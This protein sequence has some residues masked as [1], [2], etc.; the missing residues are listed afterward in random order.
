MKIRHTAWLLQA[1]L[2]GSLAPALGACRDKAPKRRSP[3]PSSGSKTSAPRGDSPLGP[4]LRRV[5]ADAHWAVVSADLHR[6]QRVLSHAAALLAHHKQLA[7]VLHKWRTRTQRIWGSWPLEAESWKRLNL[8][9]QSG[10]ALYRRAD[11]V[12]V[13]L[14]R[15]R[16][17]AQ[18]LH[19]IHQTIRN[20]GVRK[21]DAVK[22]LRLAG[23]PAFRLDG[24][25]CATRGQL[26]A[27]ANVAPNRFEAVIRAPRRSLW[28]AP[29]AEVPGRYLQA[30]LGF[31]LRPAPGAAPHQDPG[32]V[33]VLQRGVTSLLSTPVQGFWLALSLHRRL[34]LHA[35]AV[36]TPRA[37]P[38]ASL[39]KP[40]HSGL[41]AASGAPL[42]IRLRMGPRRLGD[43]V[44]RLWPALGPVVDLFRGRAGGGENLAE[45]ML[46]GEVVLISEHAGMAGILGLRSRARGLRAMKQLMLLLAPHLARWQKTVRARGQ[47][48]DLS[49]ARINLGD[50][51]THRLTLQAPKEGLGAP[52][53]RDGRLTLL[54]GITQRHLVVA[55][56]V[57]LFR[58]LLAR[59]DQ[60][61]TGFLNDLGDTT[62]RKGFGEH[63]TV[64]LLLRPSDPLYALPRGQRDV[65]RRWLEGLEPPAQHWA[66]W[67]RAL[68]DLTDSATL[69]CEP[70]RAGVGCH[71]GISLLTGPGSQVAR[72][73]SPTPRPHLALNARY[74]E[75]LIKKWGGNRNGYL[76]LIRAL[77]TAPTESPLRAKASRVLAHRDGV[78][79]SGL[80]GLLLSAWLPWI[81]HRRATTARQEAP[82]ELN[83]LTRAL[84]GLAEGARRLPPRQRQRWYH[85]LRSTGITPIRSCCAGGIRRCQSRRADWRHATWRR[86]GFGLSGAHR[87]R[88]QL[89]WEPGTM[90]HRVVLRALGDYNCNGRSSLLQRVGTID[91]VTGKLTVGPLTRVRADD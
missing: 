49:H 88:Y 23:R 30:R 73:I 79:S 59:L 80:E 8:H 74:R 58:R 21:I 82:R 53:L 34:Q 78:A 47:G 50:M 25:T 40:G 14:F 89:L 57:N 19:A 32:A 54:W 51:P 68:V 27:C 10:G 44:Q 75:A 5:P 91:V 31:W 24:W 67:I 38:W 39:P 52:T 62:G 46:N 86:L 48:W 63:R 6:L 77:A 83:R 81:R 45:E 15:S 11:G 69:S 76:S 17:L 87:Y 20:R 84:Q 1:L 55:T 16:G 72:K 9:R 65:A 7:P 4:W 85:G 42:V 66:R 90:R 37:K 35:V 60:P 43:Q 71:L 61:D 22:P 36:T 2:L 18:T 64:T 26:S 70:L 28:K 29:L 12:T 3:V 33:A 56:D 41:A 13:A